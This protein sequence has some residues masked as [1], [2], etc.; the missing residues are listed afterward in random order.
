M[1]KIQNN[2]LKPKEDEDKEEHKREKICQSDKRFIRETCKQGE[3]IDLLGQDSGRYNFH[4]KY[5]PPSC[6]S[7]MKL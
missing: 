2:E 7:K 3:T 5:T 6:L 4:V 1:D